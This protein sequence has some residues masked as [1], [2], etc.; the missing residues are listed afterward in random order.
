[1]NSRTY[2]AMFRNANIAGA[3][4]PAS[5]LSEA[6]I[7]GIFSRLSNLQREVRL[8]REDVMQIHQLQYGLQ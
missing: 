2:R 1:M 5:R 4:S 7:E 3:R 8:I 6:A